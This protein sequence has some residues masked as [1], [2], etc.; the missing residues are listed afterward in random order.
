VGSLVPGQTPSSICHLSWF[1]RV[2]LSQAGGTWAITSKVTTPQAVPSKC[3]SNF[4]DILSRLSSICFLFSMAIDDWVV[5]C[6]IGQD[7]LLS[8]PSP[9]GRSWCLSNPLLI[10]GCVIFSFYKLVI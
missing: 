3:F 5:K 1:A 9:V 6:I 8:V 10:H 2:E 4:A 7:L